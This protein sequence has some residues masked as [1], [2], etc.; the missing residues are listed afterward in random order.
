MVTQ[1]I[2]GRDVTAQDERIIDI[3]ESASVTKYAGRGSDATGKIVIPGCIEP[4]AHA[5][6]RFVYPWARHSSHQAAPH[7]QR[8]ACAL[9]STRR[10]STSRIVGVRDLAWHDRRP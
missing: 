5:S 4:N 10:L 1:G 7:C 3:P 9:A 2:D 6:F 8:R